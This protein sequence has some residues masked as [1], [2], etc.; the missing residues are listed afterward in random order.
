M[1]TPN[2]DERLLI[3]ALE[4]LINHVFLPLKVPQQDD[5]DPDHERFLV[6][7][8]LT[9]LKEFKC[10]IATE[11]HS[12]TD[13]VVAMVR[14]LENM[15][16][17]AGCM[18]PE[19][20][21]SSLESLCTDG[22]ALRGVL[23]L[24]IRAQNCGVMVSKRENSILF[25]AFE[26]LPPNTDVM[27]TQGRLRRSFPGPALS[28]K[29][30]HFKDP[31]LQAVVAETLAKMSRQSAPGTRPK[32]KKADHWYDDERETA[33]PK[34]VTEL[35]FN[36]LKPL[37]KQVEPPR[38]WK[39]TR[40]EVMCCG[41]Q[42]PW[43]RSSLWLLLR[44]GIQFFTLQAFETWVASHLDAWIKAHQ[45]EW[46][47]CGELSRLIQTYH[48]VAAPFY[49]GNPVATSNMILTVVELWVVCDK[50]ATSIDKTIL[51]YD[52]GIPEN[53]F[54]CLLLPSHSQLLSLK[55]TED[56]VRFR[57]EA[58]SWPALLTF[59]SFGHPNSFSV[60][61]FSQPLRHQE[62]LKSIEAQAR[63]AREA[64]R[65]EL[66]RMK[67]EYIA[68]M[69]IYDKMS[70]DMYQYQDTNDKTTKYHDSKC[71]R[72]AY[73]DK[74]QQLRISAHVWPL[75]KRPIEVQ[76]V[77]FELK[78]P[79]WYGSWRDTA[80]YLLL[81]VFGLEVSTKNK[82]RPKLSLSSYPGLQ[83][84]F[85]PYD[86]TCRL[87]LSSNTNAYG[88][89]YQPIIGVTEEAVCLEN[90]IKYSYLDKATSL[91]VNS[92]ETL[93]DKSSVFCIYKLPPRSSELQQYLWR[94]AVMPNDPPPNKVISSQLDCPKH[95]SFEEYIALTHLLLGL[96]I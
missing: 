4:Y 25:E 37:C 63:E 96:R 91:F 31:N 62:L 32:V 13:L 43:R 34:M 86:I 12:T 80:L 93:S 8:V 24:H 50:S 45:S 65:A 44:V 83:C 54:Q 58:S 14:N 92:V 84:Y 66:R 68:L 9:A 49:L 89:T 87:C 71:Q 51:E 17:P 56:Y 73:R 35:F 40:S 23:L 29:V 67:E 5:H 27:A 38:V 53:V 72:C 30:E 57:V 21:L 1:T 26:L 59:Q 52:V 41:S 20:L 28:M 78:V 19:Q 61:Y 75:P 33:H 94:L 81:D 18:D 15:L 60:K 76:S 39:N 42:L 10:Y 77:V 22:Q 11:W 82:S 85:E 64:K 55:N 7:F 48:K 70:C 46:N 95:M 88:S 79:Q 6:G 47:T 2:A 90:A 3:G 69:H 16:D 36:F 74:A